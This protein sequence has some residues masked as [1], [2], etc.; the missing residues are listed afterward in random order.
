MTSIGDVVDVMRRAVGQLP[1]AA[2]AD[3]L[4]LVE[5][6]LAL[7]RTALLGSEDDEAS[8]V[9]ARFEE[10]ADGIEQLQQRLSVIQQAVTSAAGRLERHG[11]PPSVAPPALPP[12]SA[13]PAA[14]QPDSAA[15]T[16]GR[17]AG[18]LDALPERD[19]PGGKTSGFWVDQFGQ[20]HGPITS[21]HGE[22]RER[23]VAGLRRLGLAPARG[24]LTVADHV[25]VQVAVQV[26]E[27]GE[28]DATLAVNNRPCDFGRSPAIASCRGFSGRG[29]A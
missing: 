3:A 27:A 4:S 19:D 5:D 23:A 17:I 6:V 24:T 7:L 2:L 9:I 22:L 14:S 25:Q 20:V 16:V 29:S 15:P 28:A 26:E 13:R 12:G 18:L 8:Q 10:V 11:T 21:G 1:F